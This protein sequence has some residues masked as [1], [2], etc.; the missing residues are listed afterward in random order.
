M[1]SRGRDR[2]RQSSRGVGGPE[3]PWGVRSKWSVGHG[4]ESIP[5]VAGLM[6]GASNARLTIGE[7]WKGSESDGHGQVYA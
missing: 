2:G 3:E 5:R 4:Q 6:A 7:A 1:T